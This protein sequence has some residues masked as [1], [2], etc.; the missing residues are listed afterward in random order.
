[1]IKKILQDSLRA[2]EKKPE[3]TVNYLEEIE[4]RLAAKLG[5]RVKLVSGRK[6][7][8]I[9]LEFYD[10]EDLEKLI[11]FLDTCRFQSQEGI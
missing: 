3:I 8:R 9:E 2:Q 5:R 11:D 4:R 10:P 1:M 6:K 7:G